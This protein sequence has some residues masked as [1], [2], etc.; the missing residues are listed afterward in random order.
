MEC[1]IGFK[2][3]Y[4][5]FQCQDCSFWRNDRCEYEIIIAI[6]ESAQVK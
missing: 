1:P 2:V 6:E 4:P 3:C 5:S